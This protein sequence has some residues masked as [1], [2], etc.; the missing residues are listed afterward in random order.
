MTQPNLKSMLWTKLARRLY[1]LLPVV[2]HDI[3]QWRHRYVL[4]FKNLRIPLVILRGSTRANNNHGTLLIAGDEHGIEYMSHRFF[5]GEPQQELLGKVPLWTLARTLKHLRTS[6]DLTIACTDRLSA[7]IF[8]GADYLVVPKWVGSMLKVPEDP[9]KLTQNN[10]SL[11]EDLRIVRNNQLRPDF[12]QATTDFE[13]FYHTMYVPFIRKRHGKQAVVR[14]IKQLRRCFHQGGLICVRQ[15]GQLIAGGIFQHRNQI[16]RFIALGTT[17]GDSAPVKAGALAALY[18]FIINH[19][20]ELGCKFID[21]G[22][23]HPSLKDGLL[24]Y[25]RKWGMKLIDKQNNYYDFLVHWNHFNSSVISFLSNTPL[26]FRDQGGLSAVYVIDGNQPVTQTEVEK[27][28]RS[29]WIPGLRRLYL[30]PISGWQPG[31]TSPPQTRLFDLTDVENFN[32]ST[33]LTLNK[34][35]MRPK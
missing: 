29:T 22:G 4:P 26:I 2:T 18:L 11:K 25:K 8:F 9:S 19:A 28:H 10:H 6:A 33:L 23:C 15:S 5:E 31:I 3:L 20:K 12:T 27:I 32:P 1:G 17:N 21:F 30:I 24:H 14:S 35:L 13:L 34:Q 16:L 7:R